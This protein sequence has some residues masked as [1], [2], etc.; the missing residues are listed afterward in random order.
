LKSG[1]ESDTLPVRAENGTEAFPRFA[2]VLTGSTIRFINDPAFGVV[3][4]LP[5]PV[6]KT[7][8]V[9]PNLM[10]SKLRDQ[11]RELSLKP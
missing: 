3:E 7:I 11:K 5:G 2:V 4:Q 8:L 10:G 9:L 1:C 6:L